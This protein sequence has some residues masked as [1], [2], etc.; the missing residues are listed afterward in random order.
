MEDDRGKPAAPAVLIS[1]ADRDRALGILA[2]ALAEG[3]LDA[4]EHASRAQAALRAR[5]A[6]DLGPLTADLPAPTPTRA[7]KDRKD[8]ADWLAEWRYWLG[9]LLIMSAVWGVRCLHKG[10]LTYY[11]PA[12]P[13]GVWAAV[14]LAMAVWPRN[15]EED[16]TR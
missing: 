3:R 12:A 1:D 16:A 10:E 5:T 8:M 13:L 14:L 9:G 7:E 15:G 4:P 2:A 11:W 6:D